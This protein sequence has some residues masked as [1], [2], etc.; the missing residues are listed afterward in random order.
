MGGLPTNSSQAPKALPPEWAVQQLQAHWPQLIVDDILPTRHPIEV[1]IRGTLPDAGSLC[2]RLLS[3]SSTGPEATAQLTAGY[4]QAQAVT[5]LNQ[6]PGGVPILQAGCVANCLVVV[7]PW[8]DGV[9]LPTKL[10]EG[11]LPV[12]TSLA[13][14]DQLAV[15]LQGRHQ[16]GWLHGRLRSDSVFVTP[17]NEA[18][19]V[20]YGI[21]DLVTGYQ[22]DPLDPKR[23]YVAPEAQNG[24]APSVTGD[25]YSLG[26]VAY[27]ILVGEPP[28][29]HFM[30]MP[31]QATGAG[32]WL[33]DVILRAIHPNPAKRI[34]SITDFRQEMSARTLRTMEMPKKEVKPVDEGTRSEVKAKEKSGV[35]SAMRMHVT[36]ILFF[37]MLVVTAA[38]WFGAKMYEK[39]EQGQMSLEEVILTMGM[40]VSQLGDGSGKEEINALLQQ[41]AE[42]DPSIQRQVLDKNILALK[43]NGKHE[44]ALELARK[45]GE[46]NLGKEGPEYDQM[47]SQLEDLEESHREY[48]GHMSSAG[49]A[50]RLDD[51][52][53]ETE[54]L[55]EALRVYPG[56][57]LALRWLA[58][59]PSQFA[60]S[61]REVE[62]KLR[63]WNPQQEVWH[64]SIHRYERGL[65]LDLSGHHQLRH[66]NAIGELP[67]DHLDIRNTP[68]ESISEL[69]ALSLISFRCDHTKVHHLTDL[70][71]QPIEMLGIS[72]TRI[73]RPEHL[74]H[75]PFLKEL[76]ADAQ[77]GRPN[78]IPYPDRDVLWENALGMR[79]IPL[80]SGGLL[81]GSREVTQQDYV[82]YLIHASK[83]GLTK[84]E[85]D[86]VRAKAGLLPI[87]VTLLE[88]LDYAEWLTQQGVQAGHLLPGMVYRLPDASERKQLLSYVKP[89][90]DKDAEEPPEDAPSEVATEE[91]IREVAQGPC[92]RG[93]FDVESNAKEWTVEFSELQRLAIQSKRNAVEPEKRG[94]RLV[95]DRQNARAI[96]AHPDPTP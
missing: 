77:L 87:K 13:M 55:M 50:R 53:K 33:D 27:E 34:A 93:F 29:G 36:L 64:A 78:M 82:D 76:R 16:A 6:L 58:Q 11:P 47:S 59:T 31:S 67:I 30:K 39:Q 54:A 40:I 61:W 80:S 89:P 23:V 94:L 52:E 69:S 28:S 2:I 18:L 73:D 91:S 66:I 17:K 60:A 46:I 20:G 22:P 12:E 3:A 45:M 14:I 75:F 37:G 48:E 56:H 96:T 24:G 57:P 38:L 26:V 8:R 88:A 65:E 10:K 92:H 70:S 72:H 85:A 44:E 35:A 68:V 7:S 9:P 43:G 42:A 25:V 19:M 62:K 32:K 86:E 71:A 5:A 90:T 81:Y 79:F 21:L 4:E 84:S 49:R 95:V 51:E 74:D 41:I 83:G 15:A 63:H 1:M